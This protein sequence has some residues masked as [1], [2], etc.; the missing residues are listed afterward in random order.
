MKKGN[1]HDTN[2]RRG[3]VGPREGLDA[4]ENKNV[5]TLAENRTPAIQ[6]VASYYTDCATLAPY[7]TYVNM[8]IHNI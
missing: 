4:V 7:S 3:W 8:Y 5:F 2:S 1:P 6:P